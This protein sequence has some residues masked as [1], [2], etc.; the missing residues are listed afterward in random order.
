[1]G[2]SIGIIAALGG[3]TAVVLGAFGAHA[4]KPYLN[5]DQLNMWEKGVQ[6]QFYHA[7]TIL[8]CFGILK[9]EPSTI[10]RNASFCFALGIICFSGSLYLLSTR[11]LT[12]LPSWFLGPV[13]PIGG[14]FFIV[15][16]AHILGSV[17]R[18][19]AKAQ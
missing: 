9:R 14:L 3:L 16:W 8:I 2:R 5:V 12:G 1:M 11:H 4:L 15:G 10:I 18:K 17:L 6:Y 13:T 7:I 19:D